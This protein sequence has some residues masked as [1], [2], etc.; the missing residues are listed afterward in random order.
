MSK[1]EN[2]VQNFERMTNYA[3]VTKTKNLILEKKKVITSS[4]GDV[5]GYCKRLSNKVEYFTVYK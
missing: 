2:A 3:V 1:Y 4:I 5:L